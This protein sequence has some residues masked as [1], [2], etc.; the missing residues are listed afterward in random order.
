LRTPRFHLAILSLAIV[1]TSLGFST[2][3]NQE[4]L[5]PQSVQAMIQSEQQTVWQV[6][7]TIKLTSGR[8]DWTEEWYN[9]QPDELIKDGLWFE[10]HTREYLMNTD[11]LF[12][13][14][15][16]VLNWS[17]VNDAYLGFDNWTD[18]EEY[19]AENSTWWLDWS[20]NLD[21]NRYGISA[22]RTFVETS[23]DGDV[24]FITVWCHVTQVA[25][26]LIGASLGIGES[27]DMRSISLGK[28]E[29]Y[30]YYLD[31]TATDQSIYTHFSAPSNILQTKGD[32]FI[33]TIHTD[34]LK[35]KQPNKYDRNIMIV[36]PSTSDIK[37]AETPDS[38]I[39]A[40][41]DRNVA[42]FRILHNESLP[43]YFSVTSGP[44]QK[45]WG[46]V[47]AEQIVSPEVFGT[48]IGF[49]I[50]FPSSIQGA[51]MIRR[52]KTYNRLMDLSVKIYQQYKADPLA[53]GKEMDNLTD[54]I[55][56][57]FIDNRLTD[58]QLERLLHRR[59][60]IV[61]RLK[62]TS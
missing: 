9:P 62:P 28:L 21:S 35:Q 8:M 15:D 11:D 22:N 10:Y 26:Y 60:D 38:N 50:L 19:V 18:F 7:D 40:K 55:F 61:A 14:L 45:W 25:E 5:W 54:S 6:N 17:A 37:R 44:Y 36:M 23:L 57:S 20:W 4:T 41:M 39:E 16:E 58:E 46:Q 29:T 1:A 34:P 49:I 47:V 33:A 43:S 27:F 30:E 2:L 59:D 32:L 24:A 3:L 42:T 12:L 13:K 51:K 31:Y 53:F 52:S 48:I 56:K